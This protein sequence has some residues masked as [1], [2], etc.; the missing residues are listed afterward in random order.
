MSEIPFSCSCG[1]ITG[2]LG[3]D[4]PREGNHLVCHCPDCR[5]AVTHLTGAAPEAGVE[6][7]QTLPDRIH[8]T[9]GADRLAILRLSPKGILR[10]Y[11]SCCGA[12]LF[13]TLK[14]PKLPFVGIAVARLADAAPLG[15]LKGRAYLPRQGGGYRHEGFNRIGLTVL[16][17]MITARLSG[18]W[19]DTPFFDESGA[20]V[21]PI[22]VLSREERAA[23]T[24]SAGP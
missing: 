17:N 19:R 2:A 12:P 6:L 18:R 22:R 24:A 20:P 10:W 11:A 7:F 13:N 16:R 14:S 9:Q 8:I 23:A 5:A 1:A 4:S 21:A 15:P 3:I